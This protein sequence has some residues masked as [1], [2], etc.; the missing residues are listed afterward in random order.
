MISIVSMVK[1][2]AKITFNKKEEPVGRSF[3]HFRVTYRDSSCDY[4][5]FPYEVYQG[6]M[7][8]MVR[9]KVAARFQSKMEAMSDGAVSVDFITESEY[10]AG[11]SRLSL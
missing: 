10:E 5:K 3:A 4:V 6:E 8:A 11:R 2:T 1:G 7:E 9:A